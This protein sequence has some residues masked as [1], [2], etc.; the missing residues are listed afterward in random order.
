MLVD[1]KNKRDL[2]TQLGNSYEEVSNEQK[3]LIPG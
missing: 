3:K 1:V 2:E